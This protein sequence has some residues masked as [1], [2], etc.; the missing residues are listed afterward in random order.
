[1]FG[2]DKEAVGEDSCRG[3]TYPWSATAVPRSSDC[4]HLASSST[5]LFQLCRTIELPTFNC[6]IATV[7]PVS[8]QKF[9]K[10]SPVNY[11]IVELLDSATRIVPVRPFR[12]GKNIDYN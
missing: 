8:D 10:K 7:T 12:R 6:D 5:R 9:G 4:T 2:F 1:M 3:C 11:S